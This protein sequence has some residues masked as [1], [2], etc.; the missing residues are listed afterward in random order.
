MTGQAFDQD[1][2]CT[3][4]QRHRN[5]GC[6]CDRDEAVDHRQDHGLRAVPEPVD[7]PLPPGDE[8]LPE[9]VRDT[10]DHG[11]LLHGLRTG[12]WLDAQT[13]PPLSYVV[14]G[15]IPE[16]FTLLVG[17]PKIG[18]SWLVLGCALALASG[19]RA[20]GALSVKSRPVLL[21]ALEDG[22]RRMQDR[23]RV[24][25]H[26]DPIP[27]GFEYM[28]SLA[29]PGCVVETISKWLDRHAGKDPLVI[30]DT[31]GKVM[32]PALPG[33]SS[34]Q[35]DYRVG[36]ALKRA[37]DAHPGAALVG[38]HHDRKAAADD[39]V[40]S[41]SGT[42]G[43]AGAADTVIVLARKRHEAT[44]QLKVTGRDV[45]EGEYALTLDGG[46]W[47]LDGADLDAAARAAEQARTTEG[48]GDRSAEIVAFVAEHP[49]GVR[50]AHVAEALDMDGK[51]AGIYLARAA[52]AGRLARPSRGLYVPVGS[53]RSVE[54]AA[55]LPA[56][57][58][59]PN[60]PNSGPCERCGRPADRLVH[61][62]C[63]RCA[64]PTEP[65]DEDD[66]QADDP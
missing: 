56:A 24:L 29:R 31:L 36:S 66:E 49:R 44:G 25:L 34:Y 1:G 63:P 53:V 8:P 18:K 14:P 4:C 39:F 42:H 6:P 62:R 61:G 21:L 20:L 10:G 65:A 50:A 41:V 54:S 60:T 35:R 16:G 46:A 30:L 47:A 5:E 48:I 64:Y 27:A 17:P 58:N 12:R 55:H 28:T 22:D 15:V 40:D 43:L 51:Q 57:S 2:F 9:E 7:V 59:T 33:E 52:D 13:F 19:G 37:V 32:P 38:N 11:E 26:G 45:A 23:C 3:G